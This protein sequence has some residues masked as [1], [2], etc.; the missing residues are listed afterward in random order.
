MTNQSPSAVNLLSSNLTNIINYISS[1]HYK[2]QGTPNYL[3]GLVDL[4]SESLDSYVAAG[5]DPVD[6]PLGVRAS[7]VLVNAVA[8]LLAS[9]YHMKPIV[10]TE[11]FMSTVDEMVTNIAAITERLD[12]GSYGDDLCD[13]F[14][15]FVVNMEDLTDETE[16]APKV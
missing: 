10:D 2:S 9:D 5:G 13:R 15:A 4:F 12:E 7:E 16:Y 14:N 6:L 11:W 8:D 1:D 3:S